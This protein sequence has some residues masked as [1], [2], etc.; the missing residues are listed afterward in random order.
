MSLPKIYSEEEAAALIFPSYPEKTAVNKI[1]ELRRDRKIRCI[2]AGNLVQFTE[3]HI[4]HFLERGSCVINTGPVISG[5]QKE[6]DEKPG[7][8]LGTNLE[9]DK[10]ALSLVAQQTFKPQSKR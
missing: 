3:Q 9:Q 8:S 6:K 10:R 2:E 1:K 4:M 5:S 7:T